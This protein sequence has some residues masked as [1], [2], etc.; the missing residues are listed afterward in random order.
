MQGF[1]LKIRVYLAFWKNIKIYFLTLSV[2]NQQFNLILI[3]FQQTLFRIVIN[4]EKSEHYILPTKATKTQQ[5]EKNHT[6]WMVNSF[7]N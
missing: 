6:S 1:C 5:F 2:D 7:N 3:V 4:N